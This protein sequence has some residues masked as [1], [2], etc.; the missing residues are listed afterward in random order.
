MC[1]RWTAVSEHLGWAASREPNLISDQ[2]IILMC[3]A[4]HRVNQCSRAVLYEKKNA[5]G[6]YV[7]MLS[8][9]YH[10]GFWNLDEHILGPFCYLLFIGKTHMMADWWSL[11]Q[12]IPFTFARIVMCVSKV[13]FWA[14]CALVLFSHN[15]TNLSYNFL[16]S[17]F[18]SQ[19]IC[20]LMHL[21][22]AEYSYLCASCLACSSG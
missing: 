19:P 9:R 16:R 12:F 2:R 8:S 3:L 11:M 4:W 22:L 1:W 18:L 5:R 17:I 10:F 15:T 14:C 6:L 21:R 7:I 13:L 20:R